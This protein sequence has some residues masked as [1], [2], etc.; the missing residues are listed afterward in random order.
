MLH[1]A[2]FVDAG[3]IWT[4]SEDNS[5]PGS[6]FKFNKFYQEIAIG[7][8]LGLRFDFSF[9]IM[10]VDASAKIVDPARPLGSRFILSSGF[11]DAPFDNAKFTEPVIYTLSIGYPF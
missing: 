8:G 4:I 10:R 11:Y 1:W 6:Q 2:A 5:R 7:A 3:N 9:F